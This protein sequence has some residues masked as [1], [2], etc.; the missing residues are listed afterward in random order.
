M[1]AKVLA[2]IMFCLFISGCGTGEETTVQN[3]KLYDGLTGEETYHEAVSYFNKNVSYYKCEMTDDMSDYLSEYYQS[4]DGVETVTKALYFDG[5]T[6]VFNYN[7]ICKS[8]YHSLFMNEDG[9]YEY[10]LTND[11]ANQQ[12][13][14]YNDV[15]SQ[16][17]FELMEVKREDSDSGIVLTLKVKYV[18]NE[19][20]EET[21]YYTNEVKINE[22]GFICQE[23]V[24][25]YSDDQFLEALSEGVTSVCSD[26]NKKSQSDL[27]VEIDLMKSCQGLTD[28]EVKN[29]IGL[30]Q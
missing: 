2:F 8:D 24:I 15:T 11:Y 21:S 6:S 12:L 13:Q 16:D 1:K 5:E 28:D 25:Y 3:N 26:F 22:D 10:E 14:M 4:D 27:D 17:G 9:V 23:T 20:L 19:E 29:K 30:M 18:E 7:I